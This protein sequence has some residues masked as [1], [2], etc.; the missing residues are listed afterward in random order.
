[1]NREEALRRLGATRVGRL[2]TADRAGVPHV[3]PFVFVLDRETLYWAV[4]QKPKR[5]QSLKRLENIRANPNVEVVVD[6]YSD[7]WNDLWWIRVSGTARVLGDGEEKRKALTLLR[8]KY[9]QYDSSP[10]AGPVVAI[11]AVRI[12]AWEAS[13]YLSANAVRA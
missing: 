12:K 6:N 8:N 1:M 11:D 2:A 4:D 3:V 10:P 9:A 7:N 13:S 5:S